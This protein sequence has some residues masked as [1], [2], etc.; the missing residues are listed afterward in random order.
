MTQEELLDAL[1]VL[2][3]GP[4]TTARDI[5]RRC[6]EDQPSVVRALMPLTAPTAVQLPTASRSTSE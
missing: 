5:S 2:A 3:F 1:G 6:F 4:G